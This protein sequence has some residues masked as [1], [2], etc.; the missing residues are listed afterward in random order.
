MATPPDHRIVTTPSNLRGARINEATT[1]SVIKGE[2][3]DYDNWTPACTTALQNCLSM[4]YKYDK[5]ECGVARAFG[6]PMKILLN[7]FM[8]FCYHPACVSKDRSPVTLK[9]NCNLT[10]YLAHVSM[11][12][13]D[14]IGQSLYKRFL[15]IHNDIFCTEFGDTPSPISLLVPMPR[16]IPNGNSLDCIRKYSIHRQLGATYVCHWK[17]AVIR[18]N[19]ITPSS[20][21]Y[22]EDDALI[23]LITTYPQPV[24][25][26]KNWKTLSLYLLKFFTYVS[27]TGANLYRGFTHY[28]RIAHHHEH[29]L[30][31]FIKAINH[32]G[33]SITSLE[34]WLP[35]VSMDNEQLHKIEH[36]FHLKFLQDNS[37]AIKLLFDNVVR[38]PV[39]IGADEQ[40]INQGTFVKDGVLHGLSE[41]LTAA[42]IARIGFDRLADHIRTKAPFIA[43]AREYRLTDMKGIFS[44]NIVT[45]FLGGSLLSK[46]CESR[47]EIVKKKANRCRECL[48]NDLPCQYTKV[49]DRCKECISRNT[50]CVSLL[51]FHVLWDMGSSHKKMSKDTQKIDEDST[52]FDF[53]KAN[54]LSIGF[55]G[56]HLA[57]CITNC[58]RNCSMT[59]QGC[60]YGVYVLRALRHL[61]GEHT[62]LIRNIKTAV[63]VGKD[64]QSDYHSW[65]TTDK[66]VQE[67]L[68]VA[69]TYTCTRTPEMILKY[70]E[71]AKKHKKL[72]FP[73]TIVCN[74]NGEPI[75]M[76][77]GSA[78]VVVLQRSSVAKMFVIGSYKKPKEKNYKSKAKAVKSNKVRFSNHL[79]DMTIIKN[80]L[81]IVDSGREEVI[82]LINVSLAANIPRKYAFGRFHC[83][84]CDI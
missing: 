74:L 51:A 29:S 78:C 31:E 46:E 44:S 67:V 20:L 75:V 37:D 14:A 10:E 52:E 18:D 60:N 53:A 49:G 84:V 79:S 38:Y 9:T 8:I 24:S 2:F 63:I 61:S 35:V 68:S 33:P 7:P 41:K 70:K 59:L 55:G 17:D 39:V 21:S 11:S 50:V 36:M 73:T 69:K 26:W 40:E 65:S 62:P 30:E 15:A 58:L 16:L 80:N 48:Y 56:L 54:L 42:D 43:C 64:R 34:R 3:K 28:P 81:Y 1:K 77:P 66:R 32:P 72:L 5:L 23:H 13:N 47:L 4:L 71:N 27:G 19:L 76:D 25:D 83:D 82:I 12:H 22:Q 45:S 6:H 57:K